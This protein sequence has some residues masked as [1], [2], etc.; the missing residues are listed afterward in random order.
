MAAPI[1]RAA[2]P[3]NWVPKAAITPAYGLSPGKNTCGKTSAAAV[4]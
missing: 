4:P 3:T 2:N 1:G